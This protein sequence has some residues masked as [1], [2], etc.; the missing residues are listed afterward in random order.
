MEM[1]EARHRNV[2]SHRRFSTLTSQAKHT[3]GE[4]LK[5]RIS[6]KEMMG[7]E[8]FHLD[9]AT[10]ATLHRHNQR[11]QRGGL[12]LQQLRFFFGFRS[13]LE[14]PVGMHGQ[15]VRSR[16]TNSVHSGKPESLT[17]PARHVGEGMG[18]PSRTGR[19]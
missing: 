13:I 17:I 7:F 9:G 10:V 2:K 1:K 8:V 19:L 5:A 16:G 14:K 6:W 18:K 11:T 4:K 3:R 15:A 12:E